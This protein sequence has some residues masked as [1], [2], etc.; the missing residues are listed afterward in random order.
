MQSTEQPLVLDGWIILHEKSAITKGSQTIHLEPKIM[1]VLVYL[2][3]NANRVISREELTENVWQSNYTSDEVIT[4]A[5]SV[6][7][8]KLGD[9]GKVHKY[10]KTIPKHGYVLELEDVSDPA[11]DEANGSL[12][13]SQ[14]TS[15]KQGINPIIAMTIAMVTLVVLV[16]LFSVQL[17]KTEV[18]AVTDGKINLKIDQFTA[19]DNRGSSEMVARVLSERL[20][21]TL[22]NSE[23]ANV[24]VDHDSLLDLSDARIDFIIRGGVQEIANEYQVNFHFINGSNG[25]VLWS[26]SFAGDRDAYHQLVNNISQTINYFITVA[27]KD[28]LDLHN[29]SLKS[30]QAAI[31]IHQ[32]REL[33]RVNSKENHALAI[34]LLENA[35]LSY[36][37]E[38]RLKS[39]LAWTYLKGVGDIQNGD[40]KQRVQQ[41][42]EEQSQ[43]STQDAMYLGANTLYRYQNDDITLKQAINEFKA[44]IDAEP[45]NIELITR[46]ATLYRVNGRYQQAGEL[47][48]GVIANNIDYSAAVFQWAKLQSQQNKT[49]QSISLLEDYVKRNP[50][51]FGINQLLVQLY[52][53]SG[54][55]APAINH[56]H[57]IDM[58][59]SNQ[60]LL[61][62]LA[63]SY[64][65][66]NQ[67]EATIR[68][69]QKID[70][71]GSP[72]MSFQRDCLVEILQKQFSQAEKSCQ[73]ADTDNNYRSRFH[74]AR[75]LLLTR[76]FQS[77]VQR[78]ETAFANIDDIKGKYSRALLFDQIDY[79]YALSQTE[80]SDKVQMLADAILQQ[81]Q[82]QNRM[83]Y[84]G[85]GISDVILWIA[86]GDLEKAG[87]L[88][89]QALNQGWL[90]WYDYRYGGPHPALKML[91]T[92]ERYSQWKNYIEQAIVDQSNNVNGELK[93]HP[94]AE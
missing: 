11:I 32:A 68:Y 4:R 60:R 43:E 69:Y 22:S 65:F 58:D 44:A 1:D 47:L 86:K 88:F 24:V 17:F 9:T 3:K 25:D 93:Q 75:V 7:R 14:S 87:D 64:Y 28:Q 67:P 30:L 54:K 71:T 41:L 21:T 52:I 12:V 90:H 46:L 57:K 91:V 55:F 80:Q 34:N 59:H 48:S 35:L 82:N 2:L 5:I 83:G 61:E 89:S 26:Q 45:D 85:Y 92:D 62:I 72:I 13:S 51:D 31:L 40:S 29:L 49:P 37:K 56:L 42:L 94:V 10:I 78:Y 19:V 6:L 38:T 66:L 81:L 33:R 20:M 8:K 36:P 76:D 23:S 50:Q 70:I 39:E 53:D 74:Y 84:L 63:D 27:Y 16:V 77:A 18:V 73:M 15:A 79:I